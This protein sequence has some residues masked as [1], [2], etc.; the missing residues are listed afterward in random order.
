MAG[1]IGIRATCWTALAG[2][3]ELSDR[4]VGGLSCGVWW[5]CGDGRASRGGGKMSPNDDRISR[6]GGKM[7]PNSAIRTAA[8]WW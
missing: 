6:G 1:W 7:S 8:R 5:W 4:R 3:V 2:E